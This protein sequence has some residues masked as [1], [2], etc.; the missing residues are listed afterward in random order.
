MLVR[1]KLSQPNNCW[2]LEPSVPVPSVRVEFLTSAGHKSSL[3]SD[4]VGHRIETRSKR[5]PGRDCS[6][7]VREREICGRQTHNCEVRPVEMDDVLNAG[8]C[9]ELPRGMHSCAQVPVIAVDRTVTADQIPCFDL[10]RRRRRRPFRA[11][12]V[13]SSIRDPVTDVEGSALVL[14]STMGPCFERFVLNYRTVCGPS[15]ETLS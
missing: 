1:F 14:R 7:S 6:E 12:D 15:S 5:R 4:S 2:Y 11:A 9:V 8:H 10:R 13:S 3:R